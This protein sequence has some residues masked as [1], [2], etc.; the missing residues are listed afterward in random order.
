MDV[1]QLTD[2]EIRIFFRLEKHEVNIIRNF[3]ENCDNT[4]AITTLSYD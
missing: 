3:L 4:A 2:E 1:T